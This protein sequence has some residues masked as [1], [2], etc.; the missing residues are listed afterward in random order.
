[1][2]HRV[3]ALFVQAR[4]VYFE[5]PDVDAWDVK[6]DAMKYAGPLPVI[7]HP[8]CSRWCQLASVNEKR[9]GH[10]IGDDGGLFAFAL[11]AVRRWGGVLEHPAETVA[12]ERFGLRTPHRPGGWLPTRDGGSVCQVEQG[13]YGCR[14]RKATWLYAAHVPALPSLTWGP[15]MPQATVSF[16]RNHGGGDLPRLS[17][18][19][20]S[21]TPPDF[22]RMLI[23]TAASAR[24]GNS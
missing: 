4:G 8:P 7:A 9:Y 2:T 14:A 1:V 17:K 12:W 5:Q 22:A 18:R 11:D 23:D 24:H 13:H 15:S 16:C 3:A 21:R 6:R 10:R 19:E 20:A